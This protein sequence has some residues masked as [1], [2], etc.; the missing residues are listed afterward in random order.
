MWVNQQAVSKHAFKNSTIK[1]HG[2]IARNTLPFM[3]KCCHDLIHDAG[4]L[5]V[6]WLHIVFAS[7]DCFVS[8]CLCAVEM[9]IHRVLLHGFMMASVFCKMFYVD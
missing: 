6:A 3:F 8:C 5:A 1:R 7:V 9:L 2:N 4:T